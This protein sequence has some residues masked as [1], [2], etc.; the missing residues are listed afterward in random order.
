MAARKHLTHPEIVR[1]RIRTSQLVRRLT[2]HAFGTV[3]MSA[4]QVTAALGI[5]RKALPDLSQVE[6]KD[7]AVNDV[8]DI[9]SAELDRRIAAI[10]GEAGSTPSIPESAD[11]H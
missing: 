10:E 3:D 11:I 4:T 2:D 8:R 1:S 7:I 9:D 5:L 6:Y